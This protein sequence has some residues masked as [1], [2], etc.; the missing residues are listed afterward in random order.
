VRAGQNMG[1]AEATHSR[2]VKCVLREGE[3]KGES[4]KAQRAE[5]F[6]LHIRGRK[7]VGTTTYFLFLS[8]KIK[9]HQL[10]KKF[11]LTYAII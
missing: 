1:E 7:Q 2:A 11:P 3:P 6:F 8:S 10:Q 5:E 4:P 9:P